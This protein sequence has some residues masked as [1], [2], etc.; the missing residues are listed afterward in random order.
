MISISKEVEIAFGL[1]SS[2]ISSRLSRAGVLI[3]LSY[4]GHNENGPNTFEIKEHRLLSTLIS[5]TSIQMGISLWLHHSAELEYRNISFAFNLWARHV[6]KNIA[7]TCGKTK[8]QIVLVYW[9]IQQ[10]NLKF[11]FPTMFL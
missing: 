9:P 8:F 7:R 3:R 6:R 4:N 10:K 11:R 1:L 5:I 2:L